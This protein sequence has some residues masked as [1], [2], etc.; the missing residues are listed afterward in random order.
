M[1]HSAQITHTRFAIA[2]TFAANTHLFI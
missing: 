2:K 1:C